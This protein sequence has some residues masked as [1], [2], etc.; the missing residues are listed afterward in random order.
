MSESPTRLSP[1]ELLE[2]IALRDKARTEL[3]SAN[4]PKEIRRLRQLIE[5][6]EIK[7]RLAHPLSDLP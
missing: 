6:L 5:R 7:I 4:D 2:L 1:E 3:Y